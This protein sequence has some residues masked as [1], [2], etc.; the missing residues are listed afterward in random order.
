MVAVGLSYSLQIIDEGAIAVTSNDVSVDALVTPAG[1]I[2][3]SSAA[4][5]SGKWKDTASFLQFMKKICL[6]S[7]PEVGILLNWSMESNF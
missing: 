3:I 7:S 5:E 1:Y 6:T 4:L 2:P